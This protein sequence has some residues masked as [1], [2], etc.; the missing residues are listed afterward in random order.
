MRQIALQI[1]LRLLA[2]RRSRQSN[3]TEH[4]RAYT[5][6]DC[7]D[8]SALPG[9]IPPFENDADFCASLLYPFLE[10]DDLDVQLG[11]L[12]LVVLALEFQVGIRSAAVGPGLLFFR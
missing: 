2:L 6:R 11:Q 10:L 4:S 5:L 12:R 1:H 9:A 3:D 7:L 8:G